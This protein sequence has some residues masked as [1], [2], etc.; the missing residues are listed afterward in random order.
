M[1]H[2]LTKT[3]A[4]LA[5]CCVVCASAEMPAD[6]AI[7]DDRIIGTAIARFDVG[8]D[9]GREVPILVDCALPQ[10]PYTADVF[11]MEYRYISRE[12][13]QKALRSIGQSDQ[14][15]YINHRGT[16][17]YT[18]TESVDPMAE[19]SREEAAQQAVSIGLAFFDALGIQVIKTPAD[20]DRPY[21]EEA[22]M[23]SVQERLSHQ[24]SDITALM[25]QH[26]AQW[27]RRIKYETR[28]PQYTRVDFDLM[29]DGMRIWGQPSYP[30]DYEDE[31][32]AWIGFSVGASVL[33]SDS[34]VIV[35]ASVDHA[36][37]VK[38][39]R[40]AR[41]DELDR[42]ALRQ[43]DHLVS[44]LVLAES[45]QEALTLVLSDASRMGNISAGTQEHAYQNQYMD[46]PITAYACQSVITDIYPCLSAISEEEWAML[47]YV[48]SQQQYDDGYRY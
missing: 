18:R 24:Y 41:P 23:L 48:G 15:K 6:I 39:K 17:I 29:T 26:R 45:W 33:V 27:K 20:I 21:D 13:M 40:T 28:A 37:D 12:D 47:W 2:I 3:A 1:K 36:I 19:I 31:P 32:D 35:E 42:F 46:E 8:G 44:R 34:G 16:A 14:G 9:E 4:L 38:K 22:Y 25:D 10:A 43:Y 11:E 5:C 7:R 30:V